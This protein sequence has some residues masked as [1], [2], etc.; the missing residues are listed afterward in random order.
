M[1]IEDAHFT[2]VSSTLSSYVNSCPMH[3]RWELNCKHIPGLSKRKLSD[4]MH[5]IWQEA[6]DNWGDSKL[7]AAYDLA[8]MRMEFCHWLETG[9]HITSD[10]RFHANAVASYWVCRLRDKIEIMRQTRRNGNRIQ[11]GIAPIPSKNAHWI[12]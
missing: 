9:G 6:W 2:F 8:M 4:G 11:K 12:N 7:I 1:N 3:E 10:Q 5:D